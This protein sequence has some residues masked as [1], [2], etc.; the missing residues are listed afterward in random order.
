MTT[1]EI[2]NEIYRLPFSEQKQIS[3]SLS[4]QLSEDS[5]ELRLQQALFEK[6]LLREI[7]TSRRSKLGNFKP[8]KI[9]GKP[10][11]ETIIEERR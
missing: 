2:L 7:K 9:K 4:E 3:D 1:Q 5:I 11:S 6:G 8:I 10:L